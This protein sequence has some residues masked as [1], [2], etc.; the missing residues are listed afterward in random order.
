MHGSHGKR[1]LSASRF[2][3]LH[4]NKS[5]LDSIQFNISRII[6]HL[7]QTQYAQSEILQAIVSE[8]AIRVESLHG[9][10]LGYLEAGASLQ[11][12]AKR[13]QEIANRKSTAFELKNVIENTSIVGYS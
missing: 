3:T 1:A 5:L 9:T 4:V 10:E 8:A 6:A 11:D 13:A 2:F 12:I 7:N